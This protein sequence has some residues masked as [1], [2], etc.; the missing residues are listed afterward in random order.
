MKVVLNGGLNLSVLDGW[1]LEGYDGETGWAIASPDAD[2]AA[3]DEHDAAALYELLE[4]DVIPLFH[5]RDA[6]G[7][8]Q[9]W[10]RRIKLSMQRLIPQFSAQRMLR[11]Y[12]AALY[13]PR[14][15]G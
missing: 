4:R 9:P 1:W 11:E 2:A 12:V 6:A 13:A 15:A 10:I 14:A 8:P 3:Q 7:L 5:E